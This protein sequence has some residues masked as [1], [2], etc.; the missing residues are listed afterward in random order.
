MIFVGKNRTH[1]K[2]DTNDFQ[3]RI[4]VATTSKNTNHKHS[5]EQ[6]K[7]L[8]TTLMLDFGYISSFL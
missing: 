2:G 4:R 6:N 8:R 3:Y 7:I 5:F 1:T